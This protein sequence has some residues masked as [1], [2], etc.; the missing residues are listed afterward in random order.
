MEVGEHGEVIL[1]VED[2]NDLRA[3]LAEVL[4]ELGYQVLVAQEGRSALV[5]LEQNSRRIDLL[6]TD[7]VM[8]GMNG[9][10]SGSGHKR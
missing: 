2:S 10:N 7:V 5:L 9:A 6:L 3:Y 1:I 8:P 4:R